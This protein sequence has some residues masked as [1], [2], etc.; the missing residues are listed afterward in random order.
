MKLAE[1]LI[2]RGDVQKRL[3][4]LQDRLTRSAWV[5]EGEAPHEDPTKL[6]AQVA[7]LIEQLQ[8][9][10]IKINQANMTTQL[11]SGMTLTEALALRDALTMHQNIL[12]SVADAAS[13]RVDRFGRAEIRRVPT[14][15]VAQL[16]D[17]I[18]LL[19]KQRREIDTTIQA[20]NWVTDLSE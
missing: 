5:Q 9:L 16:R 8:D 4:Q 1:A 15:D 12:R 18:D 13:E 19:A 20:A 7:S 3:A 11:E 2:L 6:R 10:I 14:I 17:E